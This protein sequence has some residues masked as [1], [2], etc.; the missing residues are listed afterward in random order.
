MIKKRTHPLILIVLTLFSL[1]CLIPFWLVLMISLS[2]EDWVTVH[3]YSFWPGKISLVAYQYLIQDAEKIVRAYGVSIFVTVVGVIVSLFVT[4]AMAYSLSRREFPLR[5]ALSFYILVTMLFSG[6]LLPWYLVYT[7]FLHVQD[8][9][10]ALIIPGL[11][12]GFNV[13][14]MRTFF[15]NSIPPSLIDSSQID[16]A[17]EFRTYFSIILPLSLPVMATIGLFI[18]VSYWNDWFTSLV[19]IQNE[20][21]FSLQYLLNKTLMNASFLQ[22]IANKAYSNTAQVT[23]PLESIRMAMAMIAI[24]P[25]VLVFP[26][27]QKYFVKGLTVGAVKG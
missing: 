25:L 11:I 4:S 12:G 5:G 20:K 23:T 8:T 7:R 15:T 3:G 10:L 9:L 26:F 27:L 22:T 1:A 6:G 21:L 13:I 14:I 18:T 2:D 17:G 19:F 16:G 24:G